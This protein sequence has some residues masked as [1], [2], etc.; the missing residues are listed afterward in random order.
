MIT[1]WEIDD[2][3]GTACGGEVCR[4]DGVCSL[5]ESAGLGYSCECAPPYGGDQC[6]VKYGIKKSSD[7][8]PTSECFAGSY[9]LRRSER[10]PERR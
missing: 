3:D 7:S 5:D 4:H 2:C 9:G 8:L 1:G 6:K 10:L